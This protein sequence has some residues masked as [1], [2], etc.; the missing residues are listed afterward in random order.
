MISK[1]SPTL[2]CTDSFIA[3]ITAYMKEVGDRAGRTLK[4]R[5]EAL[6]RMV[7]HAFGIEQP[8]HRDPLDVE[9]YHASC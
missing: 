1:D 5:H 4:V 7:E 8:Q 3:D 2:R 6:V 9:A